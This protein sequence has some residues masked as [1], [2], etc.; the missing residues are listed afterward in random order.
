M[1]SAYIKLRQR[2]RP[3]V[4]RNNYINKK[5]YIKS[6]TKTHYGVNEFNAVQCSQWSE[7]FCAKLVHQW[8][9]N[10][11]CRYHSIVFHMI[12]RYMKKPKMRKL[13]EYFFYFCFPETDIMRQNIKGH[14][15]CKER[16]GCRIRCNSI[17]QV[18][19]PATPA[20]AFSS[21]SIFTF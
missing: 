18:F 11:R 16:K 10:G 3:M 5:P 21:L 15:G 2:R 6:H 9:W 20:V 13:C 14:G 7:I 8:T 19:F 12:S 17:F 1:L 4:K